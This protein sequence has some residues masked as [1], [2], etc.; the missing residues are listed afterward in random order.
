M[1]YFIRR[2]DIVRDL[3]R[4]HSIAGANPNNVR[5]NDE[6]WNKVI[7][8]FKKNETFLWDQKDLIMEYT[9]KQETENDEDKKNTYEIIGKVIKNTTVF[10][11]GYVPGWGYR[12]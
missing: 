4:A 2:D 9:Q 7:K 11:P 3:E 1:K 6:I 12:N 5:T 8:D 10:K